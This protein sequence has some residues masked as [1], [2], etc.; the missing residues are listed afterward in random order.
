MIGALGQVITP[1]GIILVSEQS[2][3]KSEN[4]SNMPVDVRKYLDEYLATLG[5]TVEDVCTNYSI[6]M[7][8]NAMYLKKWADN[9]RYKPVAVRKR[10]LF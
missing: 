5:F 3:K 1:R 7:V 9:Y 4:L 10:K 2:K 8:C 6:R